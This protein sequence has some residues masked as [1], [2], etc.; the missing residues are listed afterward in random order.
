MPLP[1]GASDKYGNRYEAKWT[2][3]CFVQVMAEE[4]DFIHLEPVGEDGEGCEFTLRRGA[5]TE[6][7]Q[8]K[9]QHAHAGDCVVAGVVS[10][11]RDI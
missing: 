1:G 10:G 3:Y 7:H 2:A 4:A 6:F 11:H 8:V 5:V 9:R